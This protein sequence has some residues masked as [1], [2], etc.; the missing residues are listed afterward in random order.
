[1]P[2]QG[3]VKNLQNF[4]HTLL[5]ILQLDDNDWTFR[6]SRLPS[7]SMLEQAGFIKVISLHSD[8]KELKQSMTLTLQ[9]STPNRAIA[10]DPLDRFIVLSLEAFRPLVRGPAAKEQGPAPDLQPRTGQEVSDYSIRCLRAGIT[11]N[12]VHYNFYGHSNSQLKSRSCFL[13]AASKEEISKK[14]EALGDFSKMKTVGKKAKRIGLLFSSAA[15][16]MTIDPDRCE[17]IP[18]VESDDYIFTDG[19]GLIAPKLANDL[20]RRTRILFRDA[21]YTPSVFQI[22]YRGYKGVVTVDPRMAKQKALLKLRKSMKKF[23]GGEDHSFAVVEYSK[24]THRLIVCSC[25]IQAYLT[26]SL[27]S[28]LSL[29]GILTMKL[30]SSSTPL[31]SLKRHSFPSSAIT[32]DC[33]AMPNSTSVTRS[34]S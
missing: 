2:T 19:C 28:S 12:D 16:V 3:D 27:N 31:G 4:R 14:T 21:R 7:P 5:P 10:K 13:M 26:L 22:R 8:L 32:S 33:S 34:A 9:P 29:T 18:D 25:I 1:M 17:D 15:T 11:L 6:I 23:N 30:S 24:V 20:A